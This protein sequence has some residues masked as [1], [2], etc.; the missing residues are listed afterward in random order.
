MKF[1]N[2]YLLLMI[3]DILKLNENQ[4]WNFN[5]ILSQVKSNAVDLKRVQY[6]HDRNILRQYLTFDLDNKNIKII[7]NNYNYW[8]WRMINENEK[9]KIFQEFQFFINFKNYK[10]YIYINKFLELMRIYKEKIKLISIELII[11]Q[12]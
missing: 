3:K 7:W 4:S 2:K 10:Y 1:M 11:N 8:L 12:M 6:K 9:L 5:Y